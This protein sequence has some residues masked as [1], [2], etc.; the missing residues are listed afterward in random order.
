MATLH[1]VRQS[2]YSTSDFAQCLHVV[3]DNDYIV[4]SDDGCY[5]LTHP[6]LNTLIKNV[7]V[8]SIEAHTI[9]RAIVNVGKYNKVI[10]M[11][12]LVELTF[13]ADKVITW[14]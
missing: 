5:N 1:I 4:F 13:K 11:N 14:Q 7:S 3:N 8:M 2:A 6:I 9:A 10:D 12:D